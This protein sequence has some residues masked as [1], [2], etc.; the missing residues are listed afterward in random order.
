VDGAFQ[1]VVS[2]DGPRDS[3]FFLQ[4]SG[5]DQRFA[6]SFVGLRALAP[7]KP[8]VDRWYHLA[9][10]RDARTGDLTLYVDG[11][12]AASKQACSLDAA[13]TGNTVIGRAKFG[14]NQVDFVDGTVDQVHLYDRALTAQEVQDLYTSGR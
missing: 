10:V 13:S 1:T 5:A 14:G 9:G 7:D 8:E 4:Y 12:L 3:A 2:Q 11:Q 6:M